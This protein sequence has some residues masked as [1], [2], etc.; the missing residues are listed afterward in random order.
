MYCI[1]F[2]IPGIYF[3][4]AKTKEEAIQ[5]FKNILCNPYELKNYT[6]EPVIEDC[7]EEE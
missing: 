4:D 3:V 6:N 5:E 1:E 2:N 7:Y